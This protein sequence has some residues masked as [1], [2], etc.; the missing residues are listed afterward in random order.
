LF[1][2]LLALNGHLGVRDRALLTCFCQAVTKAQRGNGDV[3]DWE[4]ACRTMM[5]LARSLRLTQQSIDRKFASRRVRDSQAAVQSLL[6]FNEGC[7]AE[8]EKPWE[9][10]QDEA[11]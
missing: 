5:A 1:T 6:D 9:W 7:T 2:E 11:S 10:R 8:I 4:K 3:S